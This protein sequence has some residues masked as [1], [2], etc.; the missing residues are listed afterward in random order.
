[1]NKRAPHKKSNHAA[2]QLNQL[3]KKSQ[4]RK[5]VR[6]VMDVPKTLDD[7]LIFLSKVS[8]AFTVIEQDPKRAARTNIKI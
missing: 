1:M 8:H 4:G 7:Y 5:T 2:P 3:H 6:R